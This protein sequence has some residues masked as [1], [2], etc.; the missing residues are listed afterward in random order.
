MALDVLNE[1]GGMANVI[2]YNSVL[3]ALSM[4]GACDQAVELLN[5]MKT[6][7]KVDVRC[8]HLWHVLFNFLNTSIVTSI[9]LG[10]ILI[11]ASCVIH[12]PLVFMDVLYFEHM[13][14]MDVV[15]VNNNKMLSIIVAFLISYYTY[16]YLN[17]SSKRRATLM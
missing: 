12:R 14:R 6:E 11:F 10:S 17:G 5:R 4:G 8:A 7:S 13:T 1:I 3:H 9:N 15:R 2:T 16:V